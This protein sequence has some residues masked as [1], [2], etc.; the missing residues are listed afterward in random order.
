MKMSQEHK[1]TL[2]RATKWWF[3]NFF[4]SNNLCNRLWY[5][6]SLNFLRSSLYSDESS[7]LIVAEGSQ[8]KLVLIWLN[9]SM[10]CHSY[11]HLWFKSSWVYGTWGHTQ[12]VVVYDVFVVPLEIL[13]MLFVVLHLDLLQLVD[14]IGQW[15]STTLAGWYYYNYRFPTS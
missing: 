14:L 15:L 10:F 8:V 12:M 1:F 7:T 5:P 4:L 2:K 9:P 3:W 11:A 6:A 13:Y